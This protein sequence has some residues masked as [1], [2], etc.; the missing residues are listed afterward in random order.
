M[1][2]KHFYIVKAISIIIFLFS[3]FL[4]Y[5]IYLSYEYVWYLRAVRI[6]IIPM[7]IVGVFGWISGFG[8]FLFK[9]WSFCITSIF[10]ILEW[11]SNLASW[12]VIGEINSKDSSYLLII[13]LIFIYLFWQRKFIMNYHNK[14]S[15]EA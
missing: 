9:R 15:N 6:L 13:S 14:L 7:V 10:F 3:C 8:L 1:K 2:N 4:F 5:G 11:I 12:I